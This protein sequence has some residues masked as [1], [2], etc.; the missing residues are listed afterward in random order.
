MCSLVCT[1]PSPFRHKH[2]N[3]RKEGSPVLDNS[4]GCFPGGLALQCSLREAWALISDPPLC[5]S[6]FSG[7]P[8][9]P[10][11]R[12]NPPPRLSSTLLSIFAHC[13][14]AMLGR[15]C[16]LCFRTLHNFLLHLE[17]LAM[18]SLHVQLVTQTSVQVLSLQ[19]DHPRLCWSVFIY[20]CP[21]DIN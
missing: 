6:Y 14:L 11:V 15:V 16:L 7:L 13:P 18:W 9:G 21:R 8:W 17:F 12:T 19:W 1:C 5:S 2:T 10:N 3:K 4:P 20:L